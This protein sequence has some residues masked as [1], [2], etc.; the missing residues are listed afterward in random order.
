MSRFRAGL[1]GLGEIGSLYESESWRGSPSTHTEAFEAVAGVEL[2]AAC[3]LS[4]ERR[5]AFAAKRPHV[6]VYAAAQQMLELARPD[7]VAIATPHAT[8]AELIELCAAGGVRG[9]IIEKPLATDL[10]QADRILAACR[11]H[12]VAASVSYLRRWDVN[13]HEIKRTIAAREL[14]DLLY[15]C[16]HMSR[17][18]PYGWQAEAELSGGLLTYDPTHLIDLYLWLAG[19]PAWVSAQVERRDKTLRVEDFV[20]AT[21]GF[22]NGVRAHLEVDAYREYFEFSIDLQ[23]SRGRLEFTSGLH[24]TPFRLFRP[25]AVDDKWSFMQAAPWPATDAG[26]LQVLQIEEL[27][28]CLETGGAPTVGLAAARQVVEMTLGVYESARRD[29][30]RV[31]FPLTIRENPLCG[32]IAGGRL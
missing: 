12:Q 13:F 24:E 26:A 25:Q 9:L 23:L 31:Q 3:D 22:E 19:P 8:H 1:I 18:K 5:A 16:G 2:V 21:F 7:I 10:V 11:E 14:G 20:L 32:M 27:V 15:L 28:G 4:A 6:A 17:F 30:A 29:G